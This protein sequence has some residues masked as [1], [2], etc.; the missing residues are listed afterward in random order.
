MHFPEYFK[1]LDVVGATFLCCSQRSHTSFSLSYSTVKLFMLTCNVVLSN[2]I[3]FLIF[4]NS[5]ISSLFDSSLTLCLEISLFNSSIC[6]SN[7]TM[8]CFLLLISVSRLVR[9]NSRVAMLFLS[10]ICSCLSSLI[11]CFLYLIYSCN[12]LT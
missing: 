9:L 6:L 4:F 3:W 5:L 11:S 2:S 10:D 1:I 12:S 8:S 7:L